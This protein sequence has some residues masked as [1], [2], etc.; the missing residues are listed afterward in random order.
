MTDTQL[1]PG[2]EPF[3][4]VG[5]AST[6]ALVL[7][8]FTGSPS[9]VRLQ[10][11][12]L[13]AAG[14]HVE[15]PRLPGHGTQVDDMLRTTWTDWS[16]AA[17]DAHDVL[18]GRADQIVVMGL[19]MGGTLALFTAL[20]RPTVK[21]V[22]CVNPVTIPQPDDVVTMLHEM[23]ADGAD[24]APGVG[25]D[26]ADPDVVEVAYDGTPLAPLLSLVDD[27]LAPM[28]GR[29]GEMRMPLRLF[30]SRQDHVV[31][32]ANSENLAATYGGEVEH[33][34]LDRSYH[35]ATQDYD[36]D[37]INDESA[38]FVARVTSR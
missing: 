8:G 3:S 19:S 31:E 4:H 13:A 35:V 26:I 27:G 10:A 36:R 7:H 14:H 22:I 24:V 29:F 18:A 16:T 38:R 2:A 1:I 15:S 6:G 37:L 33:T 28:A 20:H 34:W 5:T 17:L 23:I 25:S 9:S 12:A 21:G 30:T 32:P 11:A